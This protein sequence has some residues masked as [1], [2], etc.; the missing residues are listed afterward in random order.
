M[1]ESAMWLDGMTLHSHIRMYTLY[2][3]HTPHYWALLQTECMPVH[4]E[5]VDKLFT[6]YAIERA[7]KFSV[8]T[9]GI[10]SIAHQH[11]FNSSISNQFN[12]MTFKTWTNGVGTTSASLHCISKVYYSSWPIESTAMYAISIFKSHHRYDYKCVCV[13]ACVCLCVPE[14]VCFTI[15]I[16]SHSFCLFLFFIR[17]SQVKAVQK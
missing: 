9:H 15:L 1:N 7:S 12:F 5:L 17:N 14:N 8:F 10:R 11:N 3:V 13:L 4:L 16:F 6:L 2:I